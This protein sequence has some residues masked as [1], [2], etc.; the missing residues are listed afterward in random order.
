M[1]SPPGLNLKLDDLGKLTGTIVCEDPSPNLY[2]FSGYIEISDQINDGLKYD[3]IGI[4][5]IG[6][7]SSEDFF[8]LKNFSSVFPPESNNAIKIEIAKKAPLSAKNVLLRGS[9]L[10]TTNYV[11]GK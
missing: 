8:E 5:N 10:K 6:F 4:E 3:E 7:Q 2:S 1:E 11:Y 9:R